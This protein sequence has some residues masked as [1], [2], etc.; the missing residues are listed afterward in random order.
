[1]SALFVILETEL[2]GRDP[3]MTMIERMITRLKHRG[4][5]GIDYVHSERIAMGHCHF[6]TT[7]QEINEKQ[8]LKISN[9]P[10][11]LIFDGRVDNRT[12]LIREIGLDINEARHLSDASL[13]LHAYD[14]WQS[15]CLKH[16]LGEFAFALW[17][18]WRKEL[19]VARDALGRCTLFYGW[20]GSSLLIASEPWAVAGAFKEFPGVSESAA[21]HYFSLKVDQD[22]QSFFKNIFELQPAHFLKVTPSGSSIHRYWQPDLSKKIRYRSDTEYS[23]HFLSLLNESLLCRMRA[24]TP[25]SVLLSGGLDSTPLASLAA[26]N[27]FPE[28]LTTISY[29]FIVFQNVMNAPILMN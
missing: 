17:D 29:V 4:P 22:G 12:D 23:E 1:M 5:D 28:K 8:P 21:A 16:I 14:R 15:G 24:S 26:R 3:S 13:I 11:T 20:Q 19:L 7:P 6:W 2:S 25:V 9:L 27:I 18:E 10:F